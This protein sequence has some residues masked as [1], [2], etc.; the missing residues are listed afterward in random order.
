MVKRLFI[1]TLAIHNGRAP[2]ISIG[3]KGDQKR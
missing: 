1:T 3:E 2:C